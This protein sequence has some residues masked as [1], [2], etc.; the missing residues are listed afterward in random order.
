MIV[1]AARGPEQGLHYSDYSN[2]QTF[3]SSVGRVSCCFIHGLQKY[4]EK[5][6]LD[7]NVRAM[8]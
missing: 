5:G 7:L 6:I 4:L 8:F 2:G 1:V 3:T